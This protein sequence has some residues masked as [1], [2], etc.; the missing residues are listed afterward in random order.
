[1]ILDNYKEFVDTITDKLNK[2]GI[3]TSVLY[4]DHLGYQA[5]SLDD[6]EKKKEELYQI[7]EKNTMFKL[8]K[9][10]LQFSNSLIPLSIYIIQLKQ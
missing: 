4:I 1:M 10:K 6:Y 3:D 7:G 2:L 5:S 9:R 8:E